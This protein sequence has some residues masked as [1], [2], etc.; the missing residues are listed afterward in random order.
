MIITI[1]QQFIPELKQAM[2]EVNYM[3]RNE[4]DSFW[5][6]FKAKLKMVRPGSEPAG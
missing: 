4:T 3:L 5:S 2:A 1:I 6:H